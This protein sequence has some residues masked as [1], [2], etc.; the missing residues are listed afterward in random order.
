MNG[1]VGG[2]EFRV[3]PQHPLAVVARLRNDLIL[4]H[5]KPAFALTLQVTAITLIADQRLVAAAQLLAQGRHDRCA[6]GPVRRRLVLIEADHVAALLD[7]DLLHLQGRRVLA[8]RALG[9]HHPPAAGLGPRQHFRLHLFLRP[10]P[11]PQDVRP[12]LL[13]QVLDRLAADHA[14]VGDDAHAPHV[15]PPPQPV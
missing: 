7:P 12:A 11:C 3:R 2:G 10:Q 4:V 13:L 1:H 15:K 8:V 9:M 6:A 14:P 5:G